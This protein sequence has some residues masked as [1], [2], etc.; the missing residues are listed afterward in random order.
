MPG[1]TC[2]GPCEV[3]PASSATKG[4]CP[5]QPKTPQ[6]ENCEGGHIPPYHGGC[7]QLSCALLRAVGV[8]ALP[9]RCS[10][11]LGLRFAPLR[12]PEL[13][14]EISLDLQLPDIIK[15]SKCQSQLVAGSFE[16]NQNMERIMGF[17]GCLKRL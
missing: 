7:F 4:S 6:N 5:V 3:Q 14:K 13:Q 2:G 15:C 11:I 12:L 1:A 9:L 10:F 8:P 17:S 16:G